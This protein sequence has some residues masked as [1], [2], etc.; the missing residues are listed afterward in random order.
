MQEDQWQ[1]LWGT[2]SV[3][4]HCRPGA[5][6]PEALIYD[7][8]VLPVVPTADD[9]ERETPM[10]ERAGQDW[11][12]LA[13]KEWER[14]EDAGWNPSRQTLVAS[15]LK[16]NKRVELVPWTF[17]RQEQWAATMKKTFAAAR[18]DGYFMTGTVLGGLGLAPAMARTVVAVPRYNSLKELEDAEGM[19]E[20]GP[21][22]RLPATTLLAV[23]GHELLLPADPDRDDFR[24]L[25]EALDVSSDATYKERRRSLY[26]WQQRFVQGDQT[27]AQSIKAAVEHMRDLVRSLQTST[28]QQNRW[29]VAKHCMTVMSVGATFAA[30]LVDPSL[31]LWT[32]SAS[33]VATVGTVVVDERMPKP[34]ASPGL[35]AATVVLETRQK[36]G[37]V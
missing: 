1:E 11:N 8:L 34:M 35:P 13:E 19:K 21:R 4:D 6:I 26:D 25:Q 30:A 10:Y 18:R 37:I 20:L 28:S 32:A 17:A 16:L 36:L 14:W 9:L 3:R 33:A 22:D 7:R 31:A 2:F 24:Y 12:K 27:D 29:R 5:F 23:L 15:I